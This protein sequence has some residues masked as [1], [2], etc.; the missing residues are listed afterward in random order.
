VAAI[1]VFKL[2]IGR[3][4]DREPSG[5]AS[6]ATTQVQGMIPQAGRRDSR[7]LA[8]ADSPSVAPLTAQVHIL[9][10]SACGREEGQPCELR[11]EK[12]W[13]AVDEHVDAM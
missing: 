9:G 5:A 2:L 12:C 11:G 3:E 6:E 13:I 7:R 1:N 10:T 4:D 8:S